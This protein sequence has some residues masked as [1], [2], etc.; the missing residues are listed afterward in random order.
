MGMD[1]FGKKPKNETGEYF[2]NNIWWWHPLWEYCCVVAP[3]LCAKV[4]NG[5]TNDGDGLNAKDSAALAG[6]LRK[7]IES[8]RTAAYEVTRKVT[9]DAL[10]DEECPWCKGTGTRTLEPGKGADT[11]PCSRCKTT[12]RRR[13]AETYYGFEVVN[14]VEFAGFLETCGGFEIW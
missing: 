4:E 14:V 3:D 2:R 10:P 8:G 7:E 13:P 6:L 9:I 5:H 12:G 1:V 11:E